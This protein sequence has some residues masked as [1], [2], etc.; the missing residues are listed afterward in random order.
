MSQ[1]FD[2][3]LRSEAER[4]G[5]GAVK[6]AESTQLLQHVE[7]QVAS[8]WDSVVPFDA[9]I[10]PEIDPQRDFE[11]EIAYPQRGMAAATAVS[12]LEPHRNVWNAF[13]SLRV[14][15]SPEQRLVC[16]TDN[17][18][19]TA[20]AFRLLGV[21]LRDLRQVRP[22]KKV[23][24]T[25]TVPQE[26]KSTVAANLAWA[27]ARKTEERTLLLD[28]DV[29]RPSQLRIHNLANVPGLCELLQGSRTLAESI[30]HLEDNGPWLMPAGRAPNDPLELFQSAKLPL[31][32]EQLT[33]LFDWIIVDSPPVLPLAD[34]SVWT[35]LVDGM[36]LVTR[37]GTTKKRLLERGLKALDAGKLIGALLN[38]AQTSTYNSYYYGRQPEP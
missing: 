24:I 27:L 7:E 21:R 29:R 3:L 38:C 5:N 33:S 35:R 20:E 12:E 2:A 34:T 26:G 25:S 14:D 13:R 17:A 19:P 6:D 1:I 23:L 16:Y 11:A 31:L 10:A 28:G 22:L 30:Y 18:T 36:F 9:R 8:K 32:M 15:H 37:E 4:S